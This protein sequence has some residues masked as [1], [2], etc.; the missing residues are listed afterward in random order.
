MEEPDIYTEPCLIGLDMS[1]GC[2]NK[3]CEECM[4]YPIK[5]NK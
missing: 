2:I 5:E 3:L 1:C 4:W